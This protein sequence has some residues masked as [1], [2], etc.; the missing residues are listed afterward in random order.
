MAPP[1]TAAAPRTSSR[2]LLWSGVLLAWVGLLGHLYAAH[3]TG[4]SGTDYTHHVLGFLL[5]L[6]VTGGILAG[7]GWRFWRS[8]WALTIFAIGLVQ[9]ILGLMVAREHI[10]AA[11]GW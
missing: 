4:G 8:R 6:V 9:A 3:A 5:I 7:L 10:R 1:S 2:L 11:L